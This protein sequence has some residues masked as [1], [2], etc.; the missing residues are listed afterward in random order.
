MDSDWSKSTKADSPDLSLLRDEQQC[1]YL[2]EHQLCPK[3]AVL[4]ALKE[5]SP[6]RDLCS[7]LQEQGQLPDQDLE[8]I[9]AASKESPLISEEASRARTVFHALVGEGEEG[10]NPDSLSPLA[11]P[12]ENDWERRELLGEGGMGRVLRI[13]D[14][15]LGR[16]AAL[17]ILPTSSCTPE[18]ISRFKREIH[19][20]AYLD[21][22]AIPP[23][24]DAGTTVDGEP[25]MLMK[26]IEGQTL[27]QLIHDYHKSKT[28]QGL[29]PLLVILLKVADALSYAHS[30]GIL[31]RDLKPENVMV[32]AFGEV[33][34][35]DWGIARDLREQEDSQLR[36]Q[37]AKSPE[38]NKEQLKSAG[39]TEDGAVLGTPGY[40]APEQIE[41]RVDERSDVFALGCLLTEILTHSMPVAGHDGVM[42]LL[43]TAGNQIRSPLEIDETVP[44][45]LDS[46]ARS[47]LHFEAAERP[48][49]V[50]EFARELRAF[51]AGQDLSCHH[52]SLTERSYRWAR[53][54]PRA[55]IALLMLAVVVIVS[56][57][58]GSY[59][60]QVQQR[61][62]NLELENK[63][64]NKQRKVAEDTAK[65]IENAL[66]ALTKAQ[67]MAR[68]GRDREQIHQ[69]V[70]DALREGP[71]TLSFLM[72]AAE[73]YDQA[74]DAE[75]AKSVLNQAV[76]RHPPAYAALFFLHRFEA[77]NSKD[78]ALFWTKSLRR[79][80]AEAERRGDENEFTHFSRAV[81]LA[82]QGQLKDALQC[83]ALALEKTRR[84][85]IIFNNRGVLYSKLGQSE[86]ALDD[87]NRAIELKPDYD[88]PYLN[89]GVVKDRM[90]LKKEAIA[91]YT[92]AIACRPNSGLA[93]FNRGKAWSD[94]RREDK[95]IRDYDR[96]IELSPSYEAYYNRGNSYLNLQDYQR[97][98]TEYSQAIKLDPK[99]PNVYGNRGI[100]LS[101]LGKRKEALADLQTAL[102]LN[103]K[104]YPL[105]FPRAQLK[106][107]KG[108]ITGACEDYRVFLRH[109]DAEESLKEAAQTKLDALETLLKDRESK[110]N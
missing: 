23:V 91:D 69:T 5:C 100:V 93:H 75:R 61:N 46:L 33:M 50:E 78:P 103:P 108:D 41:G 40:M 35:M 84:N 102:T 38:L 80:L 3:H 24:F 96:S 95:A 47:A 48:E 34:V 90:G 44:P 89:R 65:R 8:S 85:A 45:E 57:L 9:R 97:A 18:K 70:L 49:S 86:K 17:K 82:G 56:L 1:L 19:I 59:L 106:E 54:H 2:I 104:I 101:L 12:G 39:L 55:L 72:A 71:R 15:R 87:F 10:E 7:V 53:R 74:N 79:L 52:Y 68:A 77:Q 73:I 99:R 21:H 67:D 29:R 16:D 37:L 58:I 64:V 20:T 26:V 36:G 76:A 30:K 42:R 66:T 22:P 60:W 14:R 32:G 105:Y 11:S 51:L 110:K 63:L 81:Q 13:H 109:S 92:K 43:N 94:L 31:H 6:S 107:L 27:L 28:G 4:L 88:F 83:Y 25:Y 62:K 98:V